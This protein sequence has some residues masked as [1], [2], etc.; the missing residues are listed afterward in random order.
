MD[1][2]QRLFYSQKLSRSYMLA[3]DTSAQ[4]TSDAL[5]ALPPGRYYIHALT[6]TARCWIRTVPF[7]KSTAAVVIVPT[8][9]SAGNSSTCNEFPFDATSGIK[10]AVID[11][12][13]GVSDRVEGICTTGSCVLVITRVGE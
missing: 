6:L 12:K 10:S 5:G 13:K 3:V 11:V 8:P 1:E 9:P 4:Q 7:A 2:N